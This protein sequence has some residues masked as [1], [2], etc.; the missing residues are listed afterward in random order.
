M[1]RISPSVQ[2]MTAIASA[3]ACT[4]ID[5]PSVNRSVSAIRP[6]AAP[7]MSSVSPMVLSV[8]FRLYQGLW[9]QVS[10]APITENTQHAAA[11]M[12]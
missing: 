8:D 5:R 10:Q 11:N 9:R 6:A 3:V 1:P 4:A 2:S 12:G 7:S